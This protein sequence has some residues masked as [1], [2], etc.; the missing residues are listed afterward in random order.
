MPPKLRKVPKVALVGFSVS[1][2]SSFAVLLPDPYQ[3]VVLIGVILLFIF[4][5]N[6]FLRHP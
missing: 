4:G 5:I 6:Y 2:L 1:W 3:S